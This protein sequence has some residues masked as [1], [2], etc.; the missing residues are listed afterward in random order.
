MTTFILAAC[1]HPSTK[2]GGGGGGVGVHKIALILTGLEIFVS[3]IYPVSEFS[4]IFSAF[5]V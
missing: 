1:C 5:K 2:G 4:F 3:Q